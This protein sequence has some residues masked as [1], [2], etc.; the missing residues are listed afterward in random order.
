MTND[1]AGRKSRAVRRLLGS[2]SPGDLAAVVGLFAVFLVLDRLTKQLASLS[3]FSLRQP[4]LS[5]SAFQQRPLLVGGLLVC[6]AIGL[7]V[8]W[9]RVMTSWIVLDHG[10]ELRLLTAPLIV[11]LAWQS[12][13]YS[14]NFV[15]GQTHLIDRVMI[16]LLAVLALA[17]PAFLLPFIVQTRL[18]V[19]QFDFP[20]GTR[21]TSNIS[22]LLILALLAL[23]AGHVL[24]M[25]TGRVSTSAIVLLLSAA[26]SS[27][28]YLPGKS[29]IAL[30]WLG[31]SDISDLPLSSYTAG[32]QGHSDGSWSRSMSELTQAG[33]KVVL[34]AT[35]LLELG[36]LPAV[37]NYR[38][39][40]IWLPLAISFHIVVFAMTGFWFLPW[41]LLELGL[42]L[43]LVRP[44]LRQWLSQNN[45]P[46]RGLFAFLSVFLAGSTLF[47]PQGLAWIDAPVSYGYRIEGV[48]ENGQRYS[49]NP[50]SFGYLGQE[51]TFFRL[52][53]TPEDPLSGGYGALPDGSELASLQQIQSF[54][55]LDR[56]Q[57][58]NVNPSSAATRERSIAF[59]E[60]F[61]AYANRGEQPFP[62]GLSPL[63]YFWASGPEQSYSFGE[64]LSRLEVTILTSIH[65]GGDPEFRRQLVLVLQMQEDGTITI[66]G[67]T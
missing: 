10:K 22:G 12:S 5:V 31:L 56:L 29:K 30:D 18:I 28:F 14:Y 62:S 21:A 16:V 27:H 32:W 53:M 2:D 66:E 8:G 25:A 26:I 39:L 43:L 3:E 41:I 42:L 60:S 52:R 47:H 59:L 40:R 51:L 55:D 34:G 48:G 50:D 33:G 61:L 45:T 65:H 7:H 11:Y 58:D 23:S 37:V 17:R 4:V 9:Q 19:G 6:G 67:D 13:L 44:P 57:A 46:A 49:V 54:A 24:H 63:P 15:L 1:V 38:L 35:L 64:P 20:F 36:A